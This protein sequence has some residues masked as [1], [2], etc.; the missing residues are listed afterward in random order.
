MGHLSVETILNDDKT[1]LRGEPTSQ[2]NIIVEHQLIVN[3]TDFGDACEMHA[4]NG[5]AVNK[6]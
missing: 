1:K 6:K 3:I 4:L 5:Q 2:V